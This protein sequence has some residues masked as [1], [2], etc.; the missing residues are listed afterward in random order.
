MKGQADQCATFEVVLP[1]QLPLERLILGKPIAEA[2]AL[3]PRIFNLCRTAQSVAAR[4][5]FG[6]PLDDG[7][8]A[9]L[10]EEILKEHRLRL[11]VILPGKMGVTVGGIARVRP[12]MSLDQVCA[13]D[14]SAPISTVRSDF[15]PHEAVTPVLSDGLENSVAGRNATAPLLAEVE[16]RY[17]RGP[18]WR[19]LGR[20][21]EL[22]APQIPEARMQEGWANVPAARGAYAVRARVLDG[23]VMTFERRTPTDALLAPD[24]ILAH[25][26]ASLPKSKS[27]LAGLLLDILDP[28]MPVS[29][30][31]LGHA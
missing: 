15:A 5:A 2:A 12:E 29:L 4:L 28:C 18:L 6:L 24:G 10:K 26:L 25:S 17:G 14:H 3:L 30:R 20:Y 16:S 19:L 13:L 9:D 7:A 23:K 1:P 21:V 27:H 8:Q 31:E 11:G 22:S